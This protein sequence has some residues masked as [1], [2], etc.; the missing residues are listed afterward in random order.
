M[1]MIPTIFS[2][3]HYF[4][5]V[6]FRTE[7]IPSTFIDSVMLFSYLTPYKKF[8]LIKLKR[9]TLDMLCPCPLDF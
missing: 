6:Y 8:R 9:I 2:C 5:A 7:V 3:Q 4:W 1:C